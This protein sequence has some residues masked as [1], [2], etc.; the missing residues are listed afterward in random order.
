MKTKTCLAGLAAVWRGWLGPGGKTGSVGYGALPSPGGVRPGG[1]WGAL[2][3][4][5]VAWG[6]MAGPALAVTLG[7]MAKKAAV[8][9]KTVPTLL[10][11]AFYIVGAT[12]VGFG[13]LKLKRHVD[14]PQQTT[15]GGG[16]V[17]IAVG[18]ALIAAPALI[19][20]LVETVGLTGE[21]S[22]DGIRPKF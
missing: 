2:L 11:I 9:L 20:A 15:I 8:D 17:A 4:V 19:N 3:A 1:C 13:F 22:T 5:V 6:W 10:E 7:E 14:H 16:M 12:V 21:T 18:A